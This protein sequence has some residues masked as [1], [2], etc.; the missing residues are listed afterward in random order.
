MSN[1]QK[2]NLTTVV[3][4]LLMGIALIGIPNM[5]FNSNSPSHI[6]SVCLGASLLFV[7]LLGFSSYRKYTKKIAELTNDKILSKWT[8]I[9]QNTPVVHHSIVIE[10]LNHL[11]T[12]ILIYIV[13]IIISIG[14]FYSPDDSAILCAMGTWF[15]CTILFFNLHHAINYYYMVM[16]SSPIEVVFSENY[17]Y[18][19]GNFYS[20]HY[21]IYTLKDICINED[22]PRSI[23]LLYG[24]VGDMASE[25]VL[26]LPIPVDSLYDPI[27]LCEY[28]NKSLTP[29]YYYER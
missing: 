16:L 15:I 4:S 19:M 2:L 21:S 24:T 20:S 8:Y 5:S 9:P 28:Y 6:I 1:R 23:D 26:T 13:C 22:Y 7:S 10:K 27:D 18:F 17:I 29:V 11:T 14:Y 12:N 25:F 3:T